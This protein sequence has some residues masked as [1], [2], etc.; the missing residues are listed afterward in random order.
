[1]VLGIVFFA[2][3][4]ANP[5]LAINYALGPL[6]SI[7]IDIDH[8]YCD[9]NDVG[10]WGSEQID[11]YVGSNSAWDSLSRHNIMAYMNLAQESWNITGVSFAYVSDQNSADLVVGGITRAEARQL[12]ISDSTLGITYPQLT[13]TRITPYYNGAEKNYY[14]INSCTLFLIES[15]INNK[16]FTVSDFE[17]VAV[18]EAGH[19]LGY[20]GHYEGGYIMPAIF[21]SI[22]STSPNQNERNHLGQFYGQEAG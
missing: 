4:W 18:H 10:T 7:G 5:V 21:E 3:C 9:T 8:W 2:I 15:E 20:L 6:P 11:V 17:K 12:G 1:M 22:V 13:P 14:S 16:A 19:A